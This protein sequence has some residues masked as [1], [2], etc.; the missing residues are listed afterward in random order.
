MKIYPQK[1][2]CKELNTTFPTS[3]EEEEDDWETF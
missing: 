2:S 1:I 3:G